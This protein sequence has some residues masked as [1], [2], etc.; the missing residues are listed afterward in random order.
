V[1]VKI[2]YFAEFKGIS[3]KD[4]E[5]FELKS[6]KIKDLIYLL[7]KKYNSMQELLWDS[8]T[9]SI[10]N[11]VSVIVNNRPIHGP[12]ILSSSLKDGDEIAFLLPVFGG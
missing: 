2:I 6:N 1:L 8:K 11:N 9:E 10:N 4:S 3:G 5:E 12:H 7:L